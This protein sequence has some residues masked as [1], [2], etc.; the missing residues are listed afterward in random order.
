MIYFIIVQ[1]MNH[2][3]QTTQ[4]RSYFIILFDDKLREV[5]AT[6]EFTTVKR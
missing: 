2:R 6:N 4:E 5:Y 3:M 1:Y